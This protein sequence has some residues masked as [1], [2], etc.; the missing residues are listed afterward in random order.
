MPNILLVS[1]SAVDAVARVAAAWVPTATPELLAAVWRA[2]GSELVIF[3]VTFACALVIRRLLGPQA[4]GKQAPKVCSKP[5]PPSKWD[6][7]VARRQVSTK[8]EKVAAAARPAVAPASPADAAASPLVLEGS[9]PRRS[10]ASVVDEILSVQAGQDAWT[11]RGS[12]LVL[13][14]YLEELRPRCKA[15]SLCFEDFGA[16]KTRAIDMFVA[17]VQCAIRHRRYH[18][19]EAVAGDMQACGVPRTRNFYESAFKQLASKKQYHMALTLYNRM[20]SDQISPSTVTLSCLISFAAEVGELQRALGFFRLLTETA[21]PSIRAYMTVLR[22]HSRR[23]DFEASYALL[24]DMERNAVPVDC[25]VLNVVLAT[26]IA[27]DELEAAQRLL[28]EAEQ[29]QPLGCDIVSYNTVLKG[30]SQRGDA[31]GTMEFL[32]RICASRFAPNAITYNTALDALVRS[33]ALAGVRRLLRDMRAAALR[34][35]RF[36]VSILVKGLTRGAVA[37][38]Y[39]QEILTILEEFDESIE[40]KFREQ[41]YNTIIEAAVSG[42]GPGAGPGALFDQAFAQ[43][44]RHKVALTPSAQRLLMKAIPRRAEQTFNFEES[45]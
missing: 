27:S 28:D 10:P 21:V 35:D 43:M 5:P 19:A 8:V 31:E 45:Q 22:L 42:Q 34:P 12:A 33:G 29:R 13:R 41:L 18:L 37:E 16:S 17:V 32:G 15:G 30:F 11:P 3:A 6:A 44:R 2:V 24:R 40:P 9:E 36:T 7:F 1:M 23:R 25:L 20:E 38:E 26:A 4:L 14:L 39:V